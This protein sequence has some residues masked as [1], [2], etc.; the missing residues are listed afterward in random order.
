MQYGI[1]LKIS[2]IGKFGEVRHKS[3]HSCKESAWHSI[4]P[5][6]LKALEDTNHQYMAASNN[7]DFFVISGHPKRIQLILNRT[8]MSKGHCR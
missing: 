6:Q 5:V 7:L 3:I 1:L 8:D 2:G 4:L